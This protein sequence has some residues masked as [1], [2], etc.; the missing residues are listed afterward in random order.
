MITASALI[1]TLFFGGYHAPF[2][3]NLPLFQNNGVLLALLQVAAF[4]V[5][6]AIWLFIFLWVRWSLPRFRYDQ[7]MGLGWKVMLP[8]ALANIILYGLIAFK[9]FG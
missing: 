4:L 6:V 7:L 3:E 2:L 5:K 8:L 9:V 1:V